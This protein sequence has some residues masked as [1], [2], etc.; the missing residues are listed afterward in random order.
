MARPQEVMKEEVNVSP[1]EVTAILGQGTR[2]E[3]NLFFDG[4]ARIDGEFKGPV[5]LLGDDV[6]AA[7]FGEGEGAVF[8]DPLIADTFLFVVAEV[9]HR[10]AVEKEGP[11][12]LFLGIGE[13][14]RAMMIS[15]ER[16]S[17]EKKWK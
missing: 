6:A 11:A 15:G 4:T 1:F 3:G 7:L 10:L 14:V 17:Q 5:L 12:S 8:H 16:E 2:F 9:I 13:F